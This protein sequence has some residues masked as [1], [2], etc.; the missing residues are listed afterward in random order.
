MSTRF[1]ASTIAAMLASLGRSDVD[2][3][4]FDQRAQPETEMASK[5]VNARW[6]G[7]MRVL[8]VVERVADV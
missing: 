5:S 2:A 8:G 6:I 1:A 3:L 7:R 4:L